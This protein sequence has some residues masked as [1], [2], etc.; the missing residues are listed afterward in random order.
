M[1]KWEFGRKS[2][3]FWAYFGAILICLGATLISFG[4]TL[5]I[6]VIWLDQSS[7]L[8]P[9]CPYLLGATL[10]WNNL[11]SWGCDFR[12]GYFDFSFFYN[13]D[14]LD[15]FYAPFIDMLYD[16]LSHTLITGNKRLNF[17]FWALLVAP[18]FF[19]PAS[20]LP[21]ISYIKIIVNSIIYTYLESRD[22]T[23]SSGTIF[24]PIR[25]SIKVAPPDQSSPVLSM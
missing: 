24:I 9:D 5:I 20:S 2:L 12:W 23:D 16:Y 15:S 3:L 21:K 17:P 19:W 13:F 22:F 6:K 11:T 8:K 10:I 1:N 25:R 7:P 18:N 14:G 4:A